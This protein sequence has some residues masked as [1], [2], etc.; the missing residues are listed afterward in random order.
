MDFD[1]QYDKDFKNYKVSALDD[2]LDTG[3]GN[4]YRQVKE[5]P[6]KVERLEYFLRVTYESRRHHE[7]WW[8][9]TGKYDSRFFSTMTIKYWGP[10]QRASDNDDLNALIGECKSYLQAHQWMHTD[11]L[12][13]RL[14]VSIIML[15]IVSDVERSEISDTIRLDDAASPHRGMGIQSIV[16]LLPTRPQRPLRQLSAGPQSTLQRGEILFLRKRWAKLTPVQAFR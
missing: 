1:T 12:T 14:I 8:D 10:F 5:D 6:Q 16:Y 4:L 3:L 11:F 15:R 7:E 13:R 2:D 9:L